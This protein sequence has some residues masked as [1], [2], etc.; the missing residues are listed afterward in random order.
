MKLPKRNKIDKIKKHIFNK[1]YKQSSHGFKP[2]GFWYSCHDSWYNWIIREDMKDFLHRYI[3]KININRNILT[4]I[5]I[6]D[7]NKLLVIKNTKDFDIFN[8][9]YGIKYDDL[10]GQYDIIHYV[11]N[12]KKVARD[13]GG[14]EICPYLSRRKKYFWYLMWD[15]AS[16]CIWDVRHIIKNI[17][18]IY[19]K[20]KRKYIKINHSKN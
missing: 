12:W 5:Q 19:E 4:T 18:L 17:E 16:G 13:Y 9:R 2:E 15:V 11:I 3:H 20:K 6:K 7:K 14:I 8:K 1:K 10:S